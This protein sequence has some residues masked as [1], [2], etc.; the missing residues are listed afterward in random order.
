MPSAF[1]LALTSGFTHAVWNAL[2]KG[3][4]NQ[5]ATTAGALILATAA[6]LLLMLWFGPGPVTLASVPWVLLA[7]LGESLY[8]LSLGQAYSK[9]DLAL[10]YAVSRASALAFIWPA[11]LLA[12]S[13]VPTS[14]ALGATVLVALGTLLTRRPGN[15]R[16]SWNVPWTLA[17]GASI[18]LYHTGYK[19]AVAAGTSAV[20][21]FLGALAIAVPALLAMVG[22]PVRKE[23]PAVLRKPV[24]WLAGALCAASFLLMLLALKSAESGRIL[25]VRNA[26]VGFALLF[27]VFGGERLHRRQWLG[28]G[29]LGTGLA[30]FALEQV[31]S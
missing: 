17:T 7:G 29:V 27:A 12:F 3:A 5:R 30:L 25:G 15:T 4:G 1:V 20:A 28:L 11:S 16:S 14:L 10:T 23:L 8:V 21:A 31:S 13:T 19:G 2:A 6:T 26:S 18:A 9:G 22:A 24:L